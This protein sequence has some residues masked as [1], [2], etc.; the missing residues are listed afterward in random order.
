MTPVASRCLEIGC[1]LSTADGS[2]LP[3]RRAALTAE[4]TAGL[5]QS[6]LG[7]LFHNPGPLPLRVTCLVPL[8]ADGAVSGFSLRI[9]DRLFPAQLSTLL[10]ARE[11]FREAVS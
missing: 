3:L 8:P 6:Q 1:S 10:Q 5:A 7:L 4:I 11:R 2:A 9:G